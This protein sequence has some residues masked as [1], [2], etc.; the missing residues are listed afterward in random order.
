MERLENEVQRMNTDVA[1]SIL[2]SVCDRINDHLPIFLPALE[3]RFKDLKKQ[4]DELYKQMMHGFNSINN[5]AEM[6]MQDVKS[7]KFLVNSL[8]VEVDILKN[9]VTPQKM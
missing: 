5:P 6:V 3:Q 1:E 7:F 4:D 2:K 8:K 9:T